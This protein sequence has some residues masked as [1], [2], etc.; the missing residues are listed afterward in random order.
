MTHGGGNTYSVSLPD[1]VGRVAFGDCQLALGRRCDATVIAARTDDQL[2]VSPRWRTPL[3]AGTVLYY[4]SR[5]QITP[6]EIVTAL[7]ERTDVVRE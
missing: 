5:R 2:L 6:A 4:L 3:P 1:A 7:R